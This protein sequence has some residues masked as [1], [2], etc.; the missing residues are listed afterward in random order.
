MWAL[1][2]VATELASSCVWKSK[3]GNESLAAR[4]AKNGD[5]DPASITQDLG[6]EMRQLCGPTIAGILRSDPNERPSTK[7]LLQSAFFQ[8]T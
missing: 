8:L 1:G 5:Y 2:V 4:V 7:M 3:Y 6:E